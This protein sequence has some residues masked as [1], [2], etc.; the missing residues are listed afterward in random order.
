LAKQKPLSVLNQF[1]PD[2]KQI[3][4]FDTDTADDE[5]ILAEIMGKSVDVSDYVYSF[6]QGGKA[7]EGLSIIGVNEA[8]NRIGNIKVESMLVDE[9]PHSW[10][11][12]VKAI[13]TSTKKV[14]YGAFEQPKRFRG[15]KNDPFAFTKA[16]H[17]AQRNAI[18]GHLPPWLVNEMIN[19]YR[20]QRGMEP[21][22]PDKEDDEDEEETETK[23]HKITTAQKSAFA[24]ANRLNKRMLR[25]GITQEDFWAT[26]K[27]RF[28]VES[29]NDITEAE[30][31]LLAAELSAADKDRAIF[32]EFVKRVR[33][34]YSDDDFSTKLSWNEEGRMKKEE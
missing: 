26:I 21:L 5:A 9:R 18:R 29:R 14:C 32:T 6:E 33:S 17:K 28:K 10:L 27:K 2:L 20:R 25:A 8:A 15:S 22:P 31:T 24:Q 4:L 11:A 30:W 16:V 19:A 7:V 34:E 23:K 13:N 3:S 12:L 1:T